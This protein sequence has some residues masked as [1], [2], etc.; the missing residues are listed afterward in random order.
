[1]G[2]YLNP[3]GNSFRQCLNS[4]IYVDKSELI[5]KTNEHVNTQQRFLCLSRPRRFGK[6]MAADMLAAYYGMGEDAHALFDSLKI[7]GRTSYTEHLNRYNV[8]KINMQEFLSCTHSVDEML[9]VLQKRIIRDIKREYPECTEEDVLPWVMKDV[10]SQ[11]DRQFVILID[12]WDCLFREYKDGSAQ[13]VHTAHTTVFD[14]EERVEKLNQAR[15]N[16]FAVP[17]FCQKFPCLLL[18]LGLMNDVCVMFQY[19]RIIIQCISDVVSVLV[20]NR[21]VRN[22]VEYPIQIMLVRVPKRE[23]QTGHSFAAARWHRKPIDTRLTQGLLRTNVRYFCSDTIEVSIS[24]IMGTSIRLESVQFLLP[25][26]FRFCCQW[27]HT[28]FKTCGV[29]AVGVYK[30][31]QQ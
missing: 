13:A 6:S 30:K 15:Q 31:T 16:D 27:I 26:R 4:R 21:I 29:P 2:S 23:A 3:N 14:S 19:T 28:A 1:M 24:L 18:F 22:D 11:T 10:Y 9:A 25:I 17:A 5:E 12:E 20:K 7:S 8:L